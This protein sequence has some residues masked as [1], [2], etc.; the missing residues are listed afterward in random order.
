MYRLFGKIL[1]LSIIGALVITLNHSVIAQEKPG[2]ARPDYADER[3]V[4]IDGEATD[5]EGNPV[6]ETIDG[7]FTTS[8]N[9]GKEKC[10]LTL[11]LKEETWI[12]E[13]W[14]TRERNQEGMI[15]PNSQEPQ[16]YVIEVSLD[17]NEWKKVVTVEGNSKLEKFDSFSPALAKYVRM[18]ITKTTPWGHVGARIGEFEIYR[19]KSGKDVKPCG[20][21]KTTWAR[22]KANQY[23]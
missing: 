2:Y 15:N 17:G 8:W 3:N 4:A 13:T 10:S 11:K 5:S 9:E 1:I 22:L 14:W 6:P 16:D 19:T 23:R 7:D 18:K 12:E 20:S 21:K